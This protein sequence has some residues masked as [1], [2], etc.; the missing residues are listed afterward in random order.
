MD[1]SPHQQQV[2]AARQRKA[3]LDRIETLRG[4]QSELEVKLANAERHP[5]DPVKASMIPGLRNRLELA[6]GELDA[7]TRRD[8]ELTNG[9]DPKPQAQIDAELA[10]IAA[11]D[12]QRNEAKRTPQNAHLYGPRGE[13]PPAAAVAA[14]VA[15]TEKRGRGRPRKVLP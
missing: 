5:G 13:W 15:A 6:R 14:G 12:H 10:V 2:N 9:I 3:R 7:A 11:R 4:Q 1:V 8:L